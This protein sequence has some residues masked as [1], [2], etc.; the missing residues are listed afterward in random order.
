[1]VCVCWSVAMAETVFTD[2]ADVV[3][4]FSAAL[5]AAGAPIGP[6][7]VERFARAITIASPSTVAGLR[8]CAHATLSLSHDDDAV[9]DRV[10][11]AVFAGYTDPADSRGDPNA[12]PVQ[13]APYDRSSSMPSAQRSPAGPPP[14]AA[15]TGSRTADGGKA[16]DTESGRDIDVPSAGSDAERVHHREFGELTPDELTTLAAA[17]AQLRLATPQRRS[18]RTRRSATG[19]RI[20]LGATLRLARRSG[21]QPMRLVRQRHRERPRR[22]VVLCD[23]SGSMEP[24]ARAMLQ[25]LYCAAGARKAEVFV[26]ATQLTRLTPVLAHT[27]PGLALAN[28][29][30]SAPDWSGGTRIGAAIR[31]FLDGYGRRGMARG[32]VVLIISDGWETGDA[33]ELGRQMARL[34]RVAYR[35]V[36]VNP[37][38]QSPRYRPLV[39][40]MAAA[41]PYC[42][43]VV[44]AHRM[45]ALDD[46]VA[47]LA[48]PV[49]RRQL[50]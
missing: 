13:N 14:S 4:R 23:I 9:V 43:A 26:F 10:F 7:R 44:S 29:G 30:E 31:E 1:M 34:S 33:A 48:D 21:G 19:H 18:R 37:R 2:L 20:D 38:T 28:A 50:S 47:A 12:P 16:Q 45:G 17:M 49:R 11:D 46:L 22:L 3:A 6:D 25:L 36:W 8:A 35:I 15:P 32:A 42:D 24:Y 41:W 5:H 39:G 40:G 27:L